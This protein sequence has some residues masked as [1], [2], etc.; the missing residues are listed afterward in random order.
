MNMVEHMPH[1][2]KAVRRYIVNFTVGPDTC[3]LWY[4]H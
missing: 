1:M 3:R 4:A 2:V